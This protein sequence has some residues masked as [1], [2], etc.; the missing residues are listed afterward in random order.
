MSGYS[1]RIFLSNSNWMDTVIHAD[2]WFNAVKLAEGQSPVGR[3]QFLGN[4]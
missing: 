2:T 4:A 1:I 3:A